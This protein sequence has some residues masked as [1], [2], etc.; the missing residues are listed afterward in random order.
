[1]HYT[2]NFIVIVILQYLL[3]NDG[4]DFVVFSA[5]FILSSNTIPYSVLEVS[6]ILLLHLFYEL[7]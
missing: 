2:Q 6:L 7:C 3:F 4:D 5:Q 1:M